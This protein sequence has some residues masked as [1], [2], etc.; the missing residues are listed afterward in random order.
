MQSSWRSVTPVSVKNRSKLTESLRTSNR[1]LV[2]RWTPRRCSFTS[3]VGVRRESEDSVAVHWWQ[4]LM[5]CP[6]LL[7]TDCES[8][9]PSLTWE[10]NGRRQLPQQWETSGLQI[11]IDLSALKQLILDNRDDYDEKVDGSKGNYLR[12]IDTSA[13]LADCL[14]KTMTSGRLSQTICTGIFDM[15]P[16]EE[17]LAIQGKTRKWRAFKKEEDRPQDSDTWTTCA[18][19]VRRVLFRSCEAA[20]Y[21][22]R[23]VCRLMLRMF[24]PSRG[25]ESLRPR[26]FFV[27]CESDAKSYGCDIFHLCIGVI[28]YSVSTALAYTSAGPLSLK[29][30]RFFTLAITSGCTDWH[31]AHSPH[32]FCA[33][34]TTFF[35]EARK[36]YKWPMRRWEEKDDRRSVHDQRALDWERLMYDLHQGRARMGALVIHEVS[37]DVGCQQAIFK[38]P[39]GEV[40]NSERSLCTR[41]GRASN[42]E[43]APQRGPILWVSRR[44]MSQTPSREK[45]WAQMDEVGGA[46]PAYGHRLKC[47]HIDAVATRV[48]KDEK[49]IGSMSRQ[50]NLIPVH[51]VQG[52]STAP[53]HNGEHGTERE[54]E[55]FSAKRWWVGT[56]QLC[57]SPRWVGDL[58][59]RQ[60]GDES[61]GASAWQAKRHWWGWRQTRWSPELCRRKPS[62]S[63]GLSAKLSTQVKAVSSLHMW[64]KVFCQLVMYNFHIILHTRTVGEETKRK[65]GQ[66]KRGDPVTWTSSCKDNAP[67]V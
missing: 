56:R 25:S 46:H 1:L 42:V 5:H 27:S 49:S 51:T 35:L 13:M 62:F 61:G 11:A 21:L 32:S 54:V 31:T 15:R 3:W 45:E 36:M 65:I 55:I 60:L 8:G 41:S 22:K 47:A 50:G 10:D 53:L 40:L 59:C 34:W 30:K 2:T 12:W 7:N 58:V 52:P 6:M 64:G 14:A 48:G 20:E 33:V 24:S 67:R 23:E 17:S 9:L 37:D 39:S 57:A 43:S 38:R 4:K 28:C 19:N 44:A 16:I 66:M 18:R 63:G 26:H 29:A